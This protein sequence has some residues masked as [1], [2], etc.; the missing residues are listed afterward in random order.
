MAITDIKQL[1]TIMGIWAHPDDE[2]FCSGGIMAQAVMN[3]QQVIC[4]TAT[5]G[6]KGIQDEQKWPAETLGETRTHELAAA[7]KILG[8]QHHHWLNC[9]DGSCNTADKTEVV[10]QLNKLIEQYKPDS[11][12]TFGPDGLTGHP[13]H[14]AVSGWVSEAAKGTGA[15]VYQAAQLRSLYEETR[16]ADERFDIFFNV[17]RPILS[18]EGDCNLVF[19]LSPELLNQK[20][21]ALQA[22]PSQ[23]QKMHE[24]LGDELFQKMFSKE[25]FKLADL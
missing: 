16:E 24:G 20:C 5:K 10:S 12:L 9:A 13:D 25:A 22:M 19:E 4:V 2:T 1:G 3:G 21:Q 15:K 6:E 11:I 7:L 23:Y 14:Q 17:T 18:E 8:I